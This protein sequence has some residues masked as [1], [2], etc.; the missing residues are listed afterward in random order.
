MRCSLFL[1]VLTL[2][3]YSP[4]LFSRQLAIVI[5]DLG[6]SFVN[7]KRSIDLPGK[8]TVAIL[9][10]APNSVGLA[11]Y[12]TRKNKEVIIHL[13]MQAKSETNQKTESPTLNV[14]MSTIQYTIILRTSLS[15]FPQAKGVSN[16]MGSL[17]TERENP[18]RLVLSATGNH[19]LYFLD[20]KTSNQSI[21]KKVAHQTGVPYVARDF[22]LDNIKS[23]KN[24]KSIMASAFTSSR[25][26]GGAVIIGHP[27]KGTLDFLER[28]LR[29]LPP[30]IDLV[31]ASQLTTIDQAAAGL[32]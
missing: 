28:E 5:D 16:H 9:P 8:V 19:G 11:E 31:F 6:Y 17:L 13:P 22:F 3:V 12:A 30:D 4:S 20:S 21:A 25:K 29:N 23:E 7:G 14:A 2:L 15:R 27:Y 24:M 1:T 10:F 32:P 26:T 18:M